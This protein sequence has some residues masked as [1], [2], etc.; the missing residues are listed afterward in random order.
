MANEHETRNAHASD[1]V[2][3][4]LPGFDEF[5]TQI[6]LLTSRESPGFQ[7]SG[8]HK[9]RAKRGSGWSRSLPIRVLAHVFTA[10]AMSDISRP[11]PPTLATEITAKSWNGIKPMAVCSA[12]TKHES[13]DL[14]SETCDKRA[15]SPSSWERLTAAPDDTCRSRQEIPS[16]ELDFDSHRE[17]RK[18]VGFDSRRCSE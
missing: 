16:L 7:Q 13:C 10:L 15:A 2:R 12:F 1:R 6:A 4:I 18:K 3:S 5:K 17:L 8:P 9:R 11:P 14:S